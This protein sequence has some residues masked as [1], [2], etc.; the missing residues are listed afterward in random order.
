MKAI[1]I[2]KF[3][4]P[5][6]LVI[7]DVDKPEPKAGFALIRVKAFGI[8]HA[9]MH[10]RKGEWAEWMPISGVECVGIVEACP[11]GEF[12]LGTAVVALMGG[13]GRTI[14]GSYAEYTNASV[15]NVVSLGSNEPPLPWDQLA[16]IPESYATAWSSLF[17]NLE[18]QKG[19]TLLIRGATSA[20]G[21]AAVNLAVNHGVRVVGTTR[22]A[23]RHQ[24]LLTL[25]VEKVEQEGPDLSK[26]LNLR[27]EDK[28]DAV[29]DL[30]GN[31]VL[32]DSLTLVRR[33]GRLCL[34]GWLGGLAPISDFNPLLQMSGGVHFSLFRSPDFGQPAFPV[35][36]V[37]IRDIVQLATD[38]KLNA[39]PTKTF[40]FDQIRE[41]HRMVEEG[42]A[43]GKIVVMGY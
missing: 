8:N 10:M 41:A 15:G 27:L 35:S 31:S 30:I 16:A 29:L 20:L 34:A 37:P 5:D 32:L 36:D 4:N 42:R 18:I 26:R 6:V 25:G 22:N 40:S 1:V 33:G 17:R 3:G 28:F 21:K 23:D 38:G 7:K 2:E 39:K 11:G 24:D 12:E 9:E 14:N 19:Q 13:L 43:N